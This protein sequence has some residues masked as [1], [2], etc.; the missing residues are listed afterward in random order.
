MYL[1]CGP[2][3]LLFFQCG[4]E[5][6]KG[7]TPMKG[8]ELIAKHSIGVNTAKEEQEPSRQKRQH[9]A[10]LDGAG[11]WREKESVGPVSR[12]NMMSSE[13][14]CARAPLRGIVGFWSISLPSLFYKVLKI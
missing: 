4:A 9:V 12:G 6:P 1:T 13:T 7:W 2:R 5:T 14:K 11:K 3:E 8:P 10:N